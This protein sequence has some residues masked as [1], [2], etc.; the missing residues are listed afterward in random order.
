[1][2]ENFTDANE[3]DDQDTNTQ[4]GGDRSQTGCRFVSCRGACLKA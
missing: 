1:M 2:T 4:A 3:D